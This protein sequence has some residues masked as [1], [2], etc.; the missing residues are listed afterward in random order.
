MTD[1]P[2]CLSASIVLFVL[3]M[4]AA[5]QLG[6][7]L[8][9]AEEEERKARDALFAQI[10]QPD[11]EFELPSL[12]LDIEP[13]AK[14]YTDYEFTARVLPPYKPKH[15]ACKPPEHGGILN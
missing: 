4:I 6:I 14:E 8:A 1:N 3:M 2:L 15:N 11:Y 10:L 5:R 9:K 13:P 12:K 7:W